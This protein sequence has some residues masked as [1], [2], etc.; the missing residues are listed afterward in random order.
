MNHYVDTY[1]SEKVN[2]LVKEGLMSQ[3][4][5]KSGAPKASLLSTLPKSILLILGILG[6]LAVILH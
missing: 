2:D 4:Y 3:A 1:V 5:Y 6:I